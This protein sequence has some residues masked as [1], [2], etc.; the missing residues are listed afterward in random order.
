MDSSSEPTDTIAA[1]AAVVTHNVG[2]FKR[3]TGLRI[4]DWLE[5]SGR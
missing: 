3:V 1:A 5:K 2:E 4:E